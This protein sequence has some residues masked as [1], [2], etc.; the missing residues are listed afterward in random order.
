M[1][2]MQRMDRALVAFGRWLVWI[3]WDEMREGGG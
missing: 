2:W 3:K 1:S